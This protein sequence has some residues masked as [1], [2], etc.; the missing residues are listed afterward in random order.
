MKIGIFLPNATFD[1]PGAPEVGGI[2]TF[3]FVVGEALQR[4]GHEVI[5]FGGEPKE[6]R[7]HRATTLT[8][9]LHPYI[10]TKSIPDIGT[11]FQ[12]LVQRLHFGRSTRRAWDRHR[13]DLVLLAKPFDWPV[14][15]WWKIS[16]P[17]LRTIM[18][19]QG[20]DFFTGDRMFYGA[21]D[22]AF[23]V[24]PRVADLAEAHTGKRPAFIPNPVDCDVFH[25]VTPMAPRE[26]WRIIGS[27]RL[28]GWKGFANLI[29]AVARLRREHGIDA[30][31]TI[32]GEGAEGGA[33]KK[34]AEA[35]GV[36]SHVHFPGRLQPDEL[37]TRYAGCGLYCQP[38]IGLDACPLATLEA[39]SAGL[40][41]L[42]SDQVGINDFIDPREAVSY[43]AR[44][45]DALKARLLDLHARRN[46][47]AWIDR[48]ARH[49][50]IRAIFA[51]ERIAQAILD[52]LP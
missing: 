11:R 4:M 43:P 22:A 40:P 10:E 5:L 50:R 51:S 7:S 52:L 38:S 1:M 6:G 15:W 36:A 37:N 20:T 24:S 31:L 16:R 41:L 48:A 47:A 18:G 39:A 12:R 14:A 49:Q 25:P 42:L 33:L 46:E 27:G 9:E 19:F 32:A 26:P 13:V 34:Q 21:V 44:D 8:L 30:E 17:E 3:S 23:A 45:I 35:L 29:E 2:E 28:I